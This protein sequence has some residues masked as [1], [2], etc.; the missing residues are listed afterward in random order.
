MAAGGAAELAQALSRSLSCLQ[1]SERGRAARLRALEAIRAEVQERPL[2]PEAVQEVFEA[3]LVRPLARCLAG[4]AAERCRELALQLLLHGLSRCERP[5]EALPVL[6]PVLA[7]RLGL[8]RGAEPCE[9]LRLGLL[10]LLGVLLR[11]GGAAVAPYLSDVV[12]ILQAALLDHYA[13]VRRESCRCAVA[14]AHAVPEHFHMQSESL[15]KPLMQTISHQH[16]R[17]RV[18]VI[19]ATGAVIQFGNGKSVDDV[20]SH[21]AQRLFDEIPKVRQAVTAVIGEWLLHLRDRYSYFHKLIPLLLGSVADDIPENMTLAWTYW[22]KIGLQW[23]KENE[24]DLKDKMDFSVPPSHYPK[25]VT[26]PGLGCREL[27]SRNLSKVLPGLCHDLT[28]WVESTRVKASQLLCVLLLHAEDHITQHMEL[29]LRALY[30]ACSDEESEVVRNCVKA[31]EL[32]GTFVSPKVSLRLITSAFEVTPKP[33]C[34]MVL[35]A[36][37]RGSPK[38]ILQPHL[39][40]L[41]NTLSQAGVCQ[42]SEELD[43]IATHSGPVIGEALHDFILILKTCLQPNKDPQMRLKLFTVFSEL[44]QKANETVNSQGLFPSYLETVIKDILAPNLQW[45]AGRTAAAIRTTA[46]SCLWALIHCQVLAPEEILQVK[47]V[48]MPQIV[49]A[50]DEDSHISR[51]LGCRILGSILKVCGRQLDEMQLGK[52][53]PEVLKRLDDASPDVRLSAAHTLTCWFKCLKDSDLKSAMRSHVEFLYQELLIHLDDQDPNTQNAVLVWFETA[54]MDFSRLHM[55]TPPQC[56]PENTGYTYALSSS[57]SSDALDFEIEHKIDPVFDSPRMSRRSLRMLKQRKSINN[58][59]GSVREMLRKN[60][61]SSPIF[62]QS[63]FLRRARDTSMVSTVLDESSIRERTEIDHF[64]GLDDDDGDPEGSDTTSLQ[65]NG[66][67]ATAETQTTVINGY[68]CS[69]CSMLS[70][71]KEVLTAYSTSS[72]PSSRIYSRDR[73]QKHAS[74]HSDY[75]GSMNIKEFYREDSH[76][77]VNE[78]SMWRAASGIFRLLI[79][80]WNELFTLMSLLKVFIL[81]KCLP[82]VSK[83]LLFLIPLL[84]LLVLLVGPWAHGEDV[85]T[86][87][88]K[89]GCEQ[90]VNAFYKILT[91]VDKVQSTDDSVY[92]PDPQPDSSHPVQP[93]K[94]TINMFDSDRISELEKQMA[95]VSDRCHHHDAEYSKVMLLLRNLQDQVA[96][97]GDRNEILKLIKNVMDQH[98]KDKRLEEKDIQK[99]LEIAKVKTMRDG[100]EH[101]QL[102]SRVKKLELELSQVKSDLLTGDSVKTSCEKIDVIHE[103]VD[104]QVKESVKMMIFGD[105]HGDFPES[106]LQWLTSNF[107]TRSDLQALLQDLELQILKNITL[108]MAVTNRSITS[109][110]V[111]NAVTN[112]GIS[113]ITEAQAQI[114]VNNALKLYS[115]DKTGMVDFALES[116]GGSILSTRCSETYETKTALISLFGIP[117][118]YFSQS[119]RVVIQGLDDEYQEEGTFL[120]QYVYDQE[121]EPLQMFTVEKSEHAFQIV[122]LRILSNWGHAEY[123]CLYRFRVHGKPAE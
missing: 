107:V 21:L 92:V 60:R 108:Q 27:V 17:V 74:T 114:I 78:E 20:L 37:I 103:K 59:S 55:Y 122:E 29:L 123:T 109:E 118:W 22:E 76:L 23:E 35:A 25:G 67:I 53:Y 66:D 2:P 12:G 30:Q 15:I 86:I 54:T 64:W 97:M 10:Q 111:T 88:A 115:Q 24:E 62:N 77:G 91:R 113:G 57:Y 39:T 121:G 61:S 34:L 8:P 69:D 116:G 40:N 1:G 79:A 38:E 3:Q 4:D 51:L 84:F 6:L 104:A 119:P 72:V 7:Q 75:C 32:I 43:V 94:D 47:D 33:S 112:A 48:L 14:C 117:L 52:A 16:Y 85:E 83:L 96:Q 58:Q 44:L 100:D 93:P 89:F 19:Q 26:R 42:R 87:K 82:K 71:R 120:G 110:V 36:V 9:E 11:R 46:V 31:A 28:D 56:T 105:Q 80:G 95:F 99:E 106:L 70:E 63:S 68:T 13:E 98:L 73:G 49:A 101:N 41:G 45:H 102:L 81:R 5:G 90:F 18:D 65:G 50:M